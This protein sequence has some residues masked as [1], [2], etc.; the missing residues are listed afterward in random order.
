MHKLCKQATDLICR[1]SLSFRNKIK[2]RWSKSQVYIGLGVGIDLVGGETIVGCGPGGIR[3]RYVER[4]RLRN[5]FAI[6]SHS[7]A[8]SRSLLQSAKGE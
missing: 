7:G 5:E 3:E 4:D 2:T 1:T 6:R 8:Q